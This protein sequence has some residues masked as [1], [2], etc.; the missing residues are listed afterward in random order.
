MKRNLALEFARVTEVAA[1]ASEQ[2]IGRGDKESADQAAVN[3]MRSMLNKIDVDGKVVIG[4]GE[5]DEAPM[6]FIG[7]EV[8]KKGAKTKIDIAVDPIEGTKM[9]AKGQPNALAVM[10][11]ANRGSFLEAPDMYME[12]LI[13]GSNARGAIDLNLPLEDNINNISKKIGKD[14]RD[15]SVVILDKPRHSQVIRDLQNMGLK[16]MAFTDGDVAGSI[17]AALETSDVDLLYGIGGAPEGVISAAAMRA[18]DGDMQARLKTRSEVKGIS[19]ENDKIS[20]TEISRCKDMGIE[21]N[22]VLKLDDLVK[23]EQVVFVA[24][25]ITNGDLLKGMK[26]SG[27]IITTYSLLIRGK[28]RTVR[29]IKSKHNIKHKPEE[30]K[31]CIIGG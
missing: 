4:E 28:T 5:I 26:K 3:A 10:A 18:L 20:N 11:V 7:E 12:K 13:V 22:K 8:G 21:V 14:L 27:D 2:W 30:T 29:Y 25:G 24:T 23:D 31:K 17:L 6:L 16:V 9:T 15:M 1:L 19:L